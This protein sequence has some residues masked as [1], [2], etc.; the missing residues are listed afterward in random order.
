M[1][2]IT[3][4]HGKV[5]MK[6][7]VA[8]IQMQSGDNL[9][10]NLQSA[11]ELLAQAGQQQVQLVVLPENFAMFAAGAQLH[12]AQQLP[13]IQA[14]LAEQAIK[15]NLWIVA[16][17]VPC[18][19]Q[20]HGEVVTQQ[21]VRASCF[22]YSNHGDLVGRYDKLH[23]F[24]V[25][26][27]D[28]QARYQESATFEAGDSVVV[29]KT[30]FATIGLS[31]CYDL[32]FPLLYQAL[33]DQGAD[34]MVVPAAFTELTGEAHWQVLLQARAIETQCLVIGAGQSGQHS[35]TRRTWGHSQI[36]DAWGRVLAIQKLEG[37]GIV[38]A[39]YDLSEQDK[40]RQQMPLLVSRWLC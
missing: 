30:P 34:I 36:I 1:V 32:R 27:A 9:E 38:I 28:K 40:I 37:A 16:G 17:S 33:R 6:I 24:D 29:V 20:P 14:W 25:N 31:I 12:T 15:H 18:A 4:N 22:V 8:A 21:R 13:L 39:D 7:K 11:A 23:L 5:A 2:K 10:A 26:I 3:P 19:Y 35:P